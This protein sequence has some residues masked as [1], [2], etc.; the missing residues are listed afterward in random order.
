MPF[1]Q[2]SV[3]GTIPA[4]PKI[5]IYKRFVTATEAWTMSWEQCLLDGNG[6]K[7]RADVRTFLTMPTAQPNLQIHDFTIMQICDFFWTL[8]THLTSIIQAR[9][10]LLKIATKIITPKK[11]Q[12]TPMLEETKDQVLL[13]LLL[14][15][16][17]LLATIQSLCLLQQPLFN[18]LEYHH[19]RQVRR[20][21]VCIRVS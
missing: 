2:V 4:F 7:P 10:V 16:G 9:P 19:H 1:P 20:H 3:R 11:H 13:L 18:L 8:P 21:Q 17:P 14:M 6:E 15:Y 5:W 12:K